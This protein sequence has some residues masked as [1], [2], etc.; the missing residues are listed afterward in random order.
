MDRASALRALIAFDR[1]LTEVEAALDSLDWSE[2]AAATLRRADIAA[3]LR[4]FRSGE[5][6]VAA[7][8]R[9]AGLVE[10]REDIEFEARH[11]EAIADALFD[12]ANPDLQGAL[13]EIVDDV[14]DALDG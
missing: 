13:P 3:I 14:L 5:L 2:A 10:S 4:R 7:V 9:W 8:E 11:A 6:D 1:S 12:L